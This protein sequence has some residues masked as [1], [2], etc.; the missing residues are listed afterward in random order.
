[1]VLGLFSWGVM[2]YRDAEEQQADENAGLVLNGRV[3]DVGARAGMDA[4]LQA[5]DPQVVLLGPSY[6]NTDLRRE[7]IAKHLNVPVHDMALLSVPNSVGSHWYAI[8]RYRLFDKGY[9]PKLVVVVSGLQSMLLTT[10]LTE[11]SW[12]NLEAQLDDPSDALVRAKASRNHSLVL[13]RAREQRGQ[14]RAAV[15]DVLRFLPPRW[16]LPSRSRR[17]MGMPATEVRSSLDRVFADE[18]VDMSLHTTNS[19]PIEVN[20]QVR[21]YDP[22]MLPSP[23]SSFIGDITDL[24]AEHGARVVWVRPP[25]SPDI[26]RD[27]DD[28]VLPGVQAQTVQMV[29]DRGSDFLDMRRLPMSRDMFKNEDHM[30]D[31]GS[32]RFS[33][34]LGVALRGLDAMH[35]VARPGALEPLEAEITGLDAK[36]APEDLAAWRPRAAWVAPG[37][38]VVFRA[39]EGWQAERG[40]FAVKLTAE[41]RTGLGPAPTV[42]VNGRTLELQGA[43]VDDQWRI[44]RADT[45]LAQP[46]GPVSIR[47]SVPDSGDWL[48]IDGLAVGRR[49]GRALWWGDARDVDGASARLFGVFEMQ[50]GERVDRTVHPEFTSPP[51]P[52]PGERVIL[53]Q[54]GSDVARFDTSKWE[55]LSDEFLR[56]QS[57]FGSRCSPLRVVEDGQILPLSNEP[58]VEVERRGQ[59]RYCHTPNAI[60]FTA[61]DGSDPY[62]NGRSYRLKLD[63]GR[64]CDGAVWLY[65]TDVF[66]VAFPE[67]RVATFRGGATHFTFAARYLQ[68]RKVALTVRLVI[69]DEVR[70]EETLDGRDLFTGPKTWTL[71]PRVLAGD[72]VVLEVENHDHVFYLLEEAA[73]SEGPLVMDRQRWEAR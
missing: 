64:R 73:L 4:I 49:G 72:D 32:I 6:A 17:G 63:P 28:T 57:A 54:P 3:T 38:Q 34:A 67:D 60:F 62:R 53:D 23:Q 65:P 5:T 33:E 37:E 1:M 7:V 51:G 8:L 29:Q 69:N 44:W 24:A 41:Q 39:E 16:F 30:N 36:A 52:V 31:E 26:P 14:V 58:C 45:A 47:V 21:A 71:S 50:Q 18:R 35:P 59:G 9:R 19:S 22:A 43:Q 2:T 46:A 25:M 70:I 12:M 11:S 56:G 68:K 13:A 61:S 10:P 40:V 48:A 15:F 27:L 20:R 42:M 55:F 66:E